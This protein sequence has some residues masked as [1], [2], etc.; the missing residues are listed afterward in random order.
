MK[1]QIRLYT[2]GVSWKTIPDSRTKIRKI[3]TR[4]HTEMAQKTIPLAAAH[5]YIIYIR[6]YP[7]R[8]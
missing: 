2:P 7:P 5:T 1:R 4:F 6:E 8:D 3:Y